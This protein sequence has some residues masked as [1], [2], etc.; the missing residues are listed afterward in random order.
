MGLDDIVSIVITR[1][2]DTVTRQGFGTYGIIAEFATSKTS[3]T[4]ARYRTYASLEEMITD[5][6]EVTDKVYLMAQAVFSQNP[7]ISS[8]FVGR[9]DSGD[10][11]WA[12]ALAAIKEA[13]N[14]WYCF[15]IVASQASTTVFNIDFVTSNS[16]VATVNGTACD[17]VAFTTDQETT[18]GLLKAE[19]EGQIPNSIVT[20]VASDTSFRTLQIEIFG[21]QVT[22]VSFVTTG[23][24]TQPTA[25]TT[26]VNEDDYKAV[27]AWAE[28]QKKLFFFASSSS[29]ILDGSSTTDVAAFLHT[30]MY[31]RTVCAYDPK[32]QGN[33]STEQYIESAWPGECLPFDVGSQTWAY[34]TLAGISPY[35][36][37][38]AQRTAA[39]AK[40][41]NLY[42][43]VAGVNITEQGTVASG[44]YIDIMRGIDAL[45][46]GIQETI[47]SSLISSRKIPF[48]DEGIQVVVGLL[49]SVLNQFTDDGFLVKSSIVVTAPLAASVSS[50]NKTTRLLPD[51]TFTANPQGA[52]HKTQIAGKLII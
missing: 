42:M 38:S 36:L 10:D 37:T 18:M 35:A 33:G 46:S 43:T 13:N 31:E 26:Y 14:D 19:I 16:I 12:E 45:A 28:T 39:L 17:A 40:K 44:E 15:S 50:A 3:P 2:S 8:I 49:K 4:F 34:K 48:T 22:A 20:V 30:A 21:S 47:F 24:A 51:I 6:W 29:G 32:A 52:I 23:G 7:K 25:S 11:T 41:A 5:G 9:K 27:A 1:E